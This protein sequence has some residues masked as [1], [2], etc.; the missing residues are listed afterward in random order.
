[1]EKSKLAGISREVV[2][3][4]PKRKFSKEVVVKPVT[5]ETCLLISYNLFRVYVVLLTLSLVNMFGC[6]YSRQRLLFHMRVVL[7]P[8][9]HRHSEENQLNIS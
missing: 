5:F 1:M 2:G 3:E 8:S 9:N 6:I 4:S 7:L